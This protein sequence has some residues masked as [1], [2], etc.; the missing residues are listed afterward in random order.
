MIAV[1]AEQSESDLSRIIDSAG[2][3]TGLVFL[4]L[5]VALIVIFRSMSKQMKKI[6]PDLPLGPGEVREEQDLQA[7]EDAVERGRDE[8]PR[9]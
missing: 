7:Q 8:Q 5:L 2:P 3:I 4:L 6:N 1:L 9:A